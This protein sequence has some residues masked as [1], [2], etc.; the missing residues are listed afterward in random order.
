MKTDDLPE[1]DVQANVRLL[2]SNL[3]WRMWRNNVGVLMDK[4][5]VPIRYGLCNDSSA[6]N[7]RHKSGDLIGV[8][9]IVIT[10]DMVG[11]RIGQFLSIE[12]KASNW[13]PPADTDADYAAQLRW[14]DMINE[15][16]GV[17]IVSTGN[18][19]NRARGR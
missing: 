2:T 4:R 3:G 13:T 16:G 1:A 10:P 15:M 19:I 12:C 11:K 14:A 8:R 17:A 6:V 18:L 7:K 5:G 9:T